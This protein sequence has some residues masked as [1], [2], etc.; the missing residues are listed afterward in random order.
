MLFLVGGLRDLERRT[1]VSREKRRSSGVA[2]VAEAGL[3][4]KLS[5][6]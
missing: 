4:E 6:K 2:M 1:S 3:I 5:E